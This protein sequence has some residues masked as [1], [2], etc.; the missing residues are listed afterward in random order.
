MNFNISCLLRRDQVRLAITRMR[1]SYGK[2]QNYE[3]VYFQDKRI[4]H[5][6]VRSE[7]SLL[8]TKK[9]SRYN[10][11]QMQM[12]KNKS[13]EVTQQVRQHLWRT[14]GGILGPNL[15]PKIFVTFYHQVMNGHE[16]NQSTMQ[17]P[18]RQLRSGPI[19]LEAKGS[20]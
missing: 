10:K 9:L 17:R 15:Q 12:Y 1:E 5:F 6:V 14:R 16:Y 19:R 2:M 18:T 13:A 7:N 3:G 20:P 4:F 11:L 8:W